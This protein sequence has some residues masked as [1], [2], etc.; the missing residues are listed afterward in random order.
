MLR[1]KAILAFV[2]GW[3][4]PLAIDR[5]AMMSRSCARDFARAVLSTYIIS[6][7]RCDR[8]R[9]LLARRSVT[10]RCVSA[11]Y[12]NSSRSCADH[13]RSS[14]FTAAAIGTIESWRLK[15]YGDR[16]VLLPCSGDSNTVPVPRARL[17]ISQ[18][19][20]SASS[21]S[22]HSVLSGRR[23]LRRFFARPAVRLAAVTIILLLVP[24]HL[25]FSLRRGRIYWTI[26]RVYGGVPAACFSGLVLA[27]VSVR[28]D[29]N[30]LAIIRRLAV[31]APSFQVTEPGDNRLSEQSS[32]RMTCCM[33]APTTLLSCVRAPF[34]RFTACCCC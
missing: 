17:H 10:V 32:A 4:S 29:A 11:L 18:S 21:Y 6:I 27:L 5:P 31:M 24:E 9:L 30:Y 2:I 22:V 15:R 20:S 34:S 26:R 33:W 16:R 1:S 7:F 25:V 14:L 28:H 19:A 8:R 3:V 23:R 13:R 12:P